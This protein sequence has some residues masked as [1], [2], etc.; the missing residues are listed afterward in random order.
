ML[1][2]IPFR[3]ERVQ[4]PKESEVLEQPADVLLAVLASLVEKGIW[5][6]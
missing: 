3:S 2:A 6:C 1:N 4:P 5:L